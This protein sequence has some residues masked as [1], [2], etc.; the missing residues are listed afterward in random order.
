LRGPIVA[1]KCARASSI[2]FDC[3]AHMSRQFSAQDGGA[4]GAA[5]VAAAF[6]PYSSLCDSLL[7]SWAI[8]R[9]NT[10]RLA[11]QLMTHTVVCINEHRPACVDL[12][13]SNSC[14]PAQHALAESIIIPHLCDRS[15]SDLTSV[16]AATQ[17]LVSRMCGDRLGAESRPSRCKT[18]AR[19][20]CG[21]AVQQTSTLHSQTVCSCDVPHTADTLVM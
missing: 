13:C 1:I 20:H 6:G 11:H 15:V 10:F 12:F 8:M 7:I 2:G 18:L 3:V 9:V 4:D 19:G 14:S 21:T 5:E 16:G 17:R